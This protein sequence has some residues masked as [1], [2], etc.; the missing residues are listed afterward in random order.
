MIVCSFG[1]YCLFLILRYHVSRSKPISLKR[2]MILARQSALI[3]TT[4]SVHKEVHRYSFNL[5]GY[6][7][8]AL[9][10]EY[11]PNSFLR[12]YTV[13]PTKL[14]RKNTPGLRRLSDSQVFYGQDKS[15]DNMVCIAITPLSLKR[16]YRI[17]L[18][19][20]RLNYY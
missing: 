3:S 6:G 7:Q 8:F 16:K 13:T 12:T 17:L 9:L 18:G 5:Q 11:M 1:R 20:L 2:E 4:F 14:S 10:P 19:I 15:I